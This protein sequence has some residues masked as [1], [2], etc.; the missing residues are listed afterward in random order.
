LGAE[1]TATFFD[2]D[3]ME[4]AVLSVGS[5]VY[6][7]SRLSPAE[8]AVVELVTRGLSNSEVARSLCIAER[9][10][11]NHLAAIYRKVGVSCRVELLAQM[12]ARDGTT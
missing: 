2:L 7:P 12:L 1:A 11:A 4:A 6:V 10:V 3:G 8:V 9:T 5:R